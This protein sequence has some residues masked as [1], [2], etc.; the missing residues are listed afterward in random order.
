MIVNQVLMNSK[1]VIRNWYNNYSKHQSQTGINARI[2]GLFKRMNKLG[3]NKYSRVLEL[4][5]GIG[6]LT[7]LLSGKITKGCIEAVDISDESVNKARKCNFRDNVLLNASDII[8]YKPVSGQFDFIILFDVLEHIPTERRNELFINIAQIMN[9]DT[10]FLLN[11]PTPEHLIEDNTKNRDSL[12]VVDIPVHLEE[13]SNYLNNSGLYLIYLETYSIWH[14][15]DY[16]YMI[17]SKRHYDSACIIKRKSLSAV[18]RRM[19][20]KRI[21]K[22]MFF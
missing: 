14:K 21:N 7:W 22:K 12:Q 6:A 11:V 9:N 17:I 5:C 19:K 13:I 10:L 16:Q 15:F 8:N 1:D 2:Y 18:L 20:I 4:G 3:L